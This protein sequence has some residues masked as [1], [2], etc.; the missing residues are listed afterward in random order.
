M[1]LYKGG[2]RN[3]VSAFEGDD[4][5]A[6]LLRA[7]GTPASL[8]EVKELMAGIAAAPRPLDDEDWLRLIAPSMDGALRDQLIALRERL[9][10]ADDGIGKP[11]ASAARLTDLRAVLVRHDLDG[12]VV[13]LADEHQGEYVARRSRRLAWLTGF[14]GSAGSAIVLKDKAAMFID[15]RY[16]VQVR[17]QVDGNL[18]EYVNIKDQ[19]PH[20]PH[21]PDAYG[22]G[23]AL[24][25]AREMGVS[26]E[27]PRLQRGV[28][29]L[30]SNQRESGKWFTRSPTKDSK[31]YFTN[32][33]CA[34][35]VLG[36]QS[37]GELPGW[38]FN[39]G[40]K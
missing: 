21:V 1:S 36:L 9:A 24:V 14:G 11:G 8:D 34:F 29:W 33:G 22:T 16:V 20:D 37:C 32:I 3:E 15:G 28:A 12:F 7:A 17:D 39:N 23:L 4:R 6:E 25:V 26:A 35:A 10:S 31:N 19:K 38:P 18:Y 27:D 5:L 40:K 30:K 13:P 2:M